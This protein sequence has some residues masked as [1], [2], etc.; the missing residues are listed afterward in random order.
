MAGSFVSSKEVPELLTCKMTER[1]KIVFTEVV[2]ATGL[3]NTSEFVRFCMRAAQ[4]EI[5]SLARPAHS[6]GDT[7]T[8]IDPR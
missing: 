1:D 2:D 7:H 6:V 4:R 5:R 3:T 8:P